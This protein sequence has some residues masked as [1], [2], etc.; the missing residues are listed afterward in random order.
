MGGKERTRFLNTKYKKRVS[1]IQSSFNCL[2]YLELYDV[3]TSFFTA[4]LDVNTESACSAYVE[5]YDLT[6]IST[7]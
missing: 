5:S 7:N 1:S 6:I 4:V 2:K 3:H